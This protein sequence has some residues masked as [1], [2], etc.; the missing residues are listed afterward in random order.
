M[1]QRLSRPTKAACTGAVAAGALFVA[2]LSGSANAGTEPAAPTA[3]QT[4]QTAEV[5]PALIHA[6]ARDLGI[7]A[8]QAR[9]RLANEAEAGADAGRLRAALGAD[10][11]GAWVRGAASSALTVATTDAAD[12]PAIE[13]RG[14]TAAVVRHSLADLDAAKARLDR[15]ASDRAGTGTGT[16][17]WYVDVRTNALVVEAVRPTAARALLTTAGVDTALTRIVRTSE[18]PRPLY[19]LRGG[20][21]YY[22]TAAGRAPPPP[23]PTGWRRA[24][25]RRRCSPAVTW[26]G[27]RSTPT[28]WPPR[29]SSGPAPRS[30]GPRRPWWARPCAARAPPRAGTAARS[31]S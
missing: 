19:D 2:G 21:A 28:G 14:A 18:Q 31:S 30:P 26:R 25:S 27:W 5:P 3:A 12:V 15:T 24:P 22:A 8:R 29:A 4:L 6:M 23:A 17:V 10:F 20:D 11:A 9:A 1:L 7:D 13:A 16:P